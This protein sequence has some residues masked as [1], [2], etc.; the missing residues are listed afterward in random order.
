MGLKLNQN[1]AAPSIA[2][3]GMELNLDT[4]LKLIFN[5]IFTF[6]RKSAV[7][8]RKQYFFGRSAGIRIR[9]G[10]IFKVN[11]GKIGTIYQDFKTKML[12]IVNGNKMHLNA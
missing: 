7:F 1:T 6:K 8:L 4:E 5:D 9:D 2:Q 3:G 11:R 12:T 10:D